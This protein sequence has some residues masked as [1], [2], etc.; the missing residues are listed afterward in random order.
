MWFGYIACLSQWGGMGYF[1]C[2]W[3]L[4]AFAAA[5]AGG[6]GGGSSLWG[7][8]KGE[9]EREGGQ[10]IKEGVVGTVYYM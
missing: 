3:L 7:K 1:T 8:G 6:K 2:S 10:V 5:R 4:P 9:G